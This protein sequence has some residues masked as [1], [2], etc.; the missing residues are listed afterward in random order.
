M[1]LLKKQTNNKYIELSNSILEL[2]SDD[3]TLFNTL[4]DYDIIPKELELTD[5]Q[6]HN[7]QLLSELEYDT[8]LQGILDIAILSIK[9]NISSLE[10]LIEIAHSVMNTINL[11]EAIELDNIEDFLAT[12]NMTNCNIDNLYY[13]SNNH[14]NVNIVNGGSIST[15]Q[16]LVTEELVTDI[17]E[18]EEEDD[19]S[20]EPTR[21]E[22]EQAIEDYGPIFAAAMGYELKDEEKQDNE[23]KEEEQTVKKK[24]RRTPF[25]GGN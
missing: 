17:E 7:K 22:I 6:Q 20:L 8:L 14:I 11:E 12:M 24:R 5:V 15:S 19:T 21:E 4:N 1:R 25:G 9:V 23:E 10:E 13:D 16:S 18:E 2:S 3:V